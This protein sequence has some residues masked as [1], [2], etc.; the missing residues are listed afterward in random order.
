MK[1]VNHLKKE[2]M[3]FKTVSTILSQVENANISSITC[4]SVKLS[5]DSSHLTIF[6]TFSQNS[7]KSFEN[8]NQI[9]GFVKRQLAFSVKARKIPDIVFKIDD[10]FEKA[11]RIEAILQKIKKGE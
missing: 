10:S 1:S 4:T 3:F 9:K 6:V 7:K 8:L 2:A 11:Q 5:N